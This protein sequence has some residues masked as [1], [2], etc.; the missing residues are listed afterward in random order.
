MKLRNIFLIIIAFFIVT[1]IIGEQLEQ[2]FIARS[3]QQASKYVQL[4]ADCALTNVIMTDEFFTSGATNDGY[5]TAVGNLN[6]A[7]TLYTMASS[8]AGYKIDTN[9]NGTYEDK[10]IF[11]YTYKNNVTLTD[12]IVTDM[13][14]MYR[15]VYT[16][17]SFTKWAGNVLKVQEARPSRKIYWVDTLELPL[18]SNPTQYGITTFSGDLMIPKLLTMGASLFATENNGKIVDW[19]TWDDIDAYMREEAKTSRLTTG[20][21]SYNSVD[22]ITKTERFTGSWETSYTIKGTT[23]SATR[24]DNCEERVR[25]MLDSLDYSNY[26]KVST[27]GVGTSFGGNWYDWNPTTSSN[28]LY[29]Y[30]TPTSLGLTYIDPEVLNVMFHS[31]MDLL[32][33]SKFLQQDIS[34]NV[35][36][37]AD[38]TPIIDNTYYPVD[39]TI[40]TDTTW[41]K[42]VVNDGSFYYLRGEATHNSSGID[43][44]YNGVT[45]PEP[46]VEYIYYNISAEDIKNCTKTDIIMDNTEAAALA[47]KNAAVTGSLGLTAEER[48]EL[49]NLLALA[50]NPGTTIER[51]INRYSGLEDY[52]LIIA[53]VTFYADIAY[54]YITSQMRGNALHFGAENTGTT[55]KYAEKDLRALSVTKEMT[56]QLYPG[57]LPSTTVESVLVD[58]NYMYEYTTYFAVAA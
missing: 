44:V 22:R 30:L 3:A 11:G 13:Q 29:Y 48:A 42:N 9:G 33:R 18:K 45:L 1:T 16:T 21:T 20:T 35:A 4:A 56:E 7:S 31:N 57:V 43:Y 39:T 36:V 54:P 27:I 49:N 10:N 14:T 41:A 52:N 40:A 55:A 2:T 38:Y 17:D 53:K 5:K 37:G 23:G 28:I 58:G 26:Q 50:I 24:I 6:D 12:N 19:S 8:I 47:N 46:K 25:G 51:L 32:V 34:G 15:A